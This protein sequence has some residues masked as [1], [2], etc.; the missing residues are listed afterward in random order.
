MAIKVRFGA[1]TDLTDRVAEFYPACDHCGEAIDADRPG[2]CEFVETEGA[3]VSLLHKECT[4]AFR[5]GKPKMLWTE[6]QSI[7]V[8]TK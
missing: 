8:K 5:A 4:K 7:D 3:T 1:N 6:L 2:N